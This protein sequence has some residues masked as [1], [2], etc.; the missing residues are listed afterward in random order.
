MIHR[1]AKVTKWCL[2]NRASAMFQSMPALEGGNENE[3]KRDGRPTI[4]GGTRQRPTCPP[5]LQSYGSV[6]T[7]EIAWLKQ[8]SKVDAY[9]SDG[10]GITGR[11]AGAGSGSF[12][13]GVL[14]VIVVVPPGTV[15]VIRRVMVLVMSSLSLHVRQ[16]L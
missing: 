9:V 11:L 15:D 1:S 6:S 5:I 13:S 2:R 16:R 4:I 7:C 14:T 10:S 12:V 3:S 8:C